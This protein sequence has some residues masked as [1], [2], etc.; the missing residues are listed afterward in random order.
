MI[1]LNAPQGRSNTGLKC[2]LNAQA[3]DPS[4]PTTSRVGAAAVT[5]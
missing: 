4:H 1:Q 3:G 5:S 2:A